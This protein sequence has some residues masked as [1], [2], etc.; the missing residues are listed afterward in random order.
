MP[1]RL[2]SPVNCPVEYINH[3]DPQE[4]SNGEEKDSPHNNKTGRPPAIPK[5]PKD[6]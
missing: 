3:A 4:G 6:D 1:D 2:Q 5:A